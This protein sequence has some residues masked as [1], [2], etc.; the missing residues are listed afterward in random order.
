LKKFAVI[1]TAVLAAAAI[2]GL[3]AF[4]VSYA[5]GLFLQ[6]QPASNPGQLSLCFPDQ[7]STP[8]RPCA[9]VMC[10]MNQVSTPQAPCAA[11]PENMPPP[12]KWQPEPAEPTS[13]VPAADEQP[14]SCGA[15]PHMD[16]RA[17]ND[18]LSVQYCGLPAPTGKCAKFCPKNFYLA[19]CQLPYPVQIEYKKVNANDPWGRPWLGKRF[20][21]A[22]VYV[23]ASGYATSHDPDCAQVPNGGSRCAFGSYSLPE[24]KEHN[25]RKGDW[26]NMANY[27][28]IAHRG[29][30]C[31]AIDP[32]RYKVCVND[33]LCAVGWSR[34]EQL[35]RWS[36][37]EPPGSVVSFRMKNWSHS[38]GRC[39][40]SFWAHHTAPG[41]RP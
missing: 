7:S 1:G 35:G 25:G 17:P 16:R 8:D 31:T 33:Q 11:W 13:P 14:C 29:E 20:L 10:A 32:D 24:V 5:N 22:Y 15:Y 9:P 2:A 23:A 26:M 40:M 39:F 37:A 34:F 3:G 19:A 30:D 4:S 36:T 28:A 41:S 21:K 27:A 18:M 38:A 6:A 12:P